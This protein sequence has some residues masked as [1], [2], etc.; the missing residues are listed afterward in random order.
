[1]NSCHDSC[2]TREDREPMCCRHPAGSSLHRLGHWDHE[3]VGRVTPCAPQPGDAQT[4]RRGLTRPTFS[5]MKRL[6]AVA[7]VTMFAHSSLSLG[8]SREAQLKEV[9]EAISK[10]LPKTAIEKLEPIIQGALRDKAWGEAAK[11][12]ARKIALEGNIQG[13]KPEERI[14]RLEAEIAQAPKEIVPLLDTILADW[15][16]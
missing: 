12:I 8:A 2:A 16:W 10:G 13:N 14:T 1:M 4:A 6:L 3:P 5:F 11:A 9:D 15:Y 7:L